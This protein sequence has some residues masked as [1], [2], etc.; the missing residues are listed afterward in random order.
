MN[1]SIFLFYSIGV[2]LKSKVAFDRRK[3]DMVIPIKEKNN[4]SIRT[5]LKRTHNLP[6]NRDKS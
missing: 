5:E 4:E 2:G 3:S 6:V 1:S